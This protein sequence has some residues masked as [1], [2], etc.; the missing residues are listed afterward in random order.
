ML[1]ILYAQDFSNRKEEI[2][3]EFKTK[4]VDTY[5][6]LRSQMIQNV[7]S[8]ITMT[9]SMGIAIGKLKATFTLN[10]V[11]GSN[12]LSEILIPL[13]T[14]ILFPLYTLVALLIAPLRLPKN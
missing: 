9:T 14:M 2:N 5:G 8:V 7:I 10:H 13:S 4:L 1:S 6:I 12:I 11:K 3:S